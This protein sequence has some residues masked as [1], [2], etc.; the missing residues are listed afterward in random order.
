MHPQLNEHRHPDC[1]EQIQAL[2]RC[3]E[4]AGY[5][6]KL[7][8]YCNGQKQQLDTC[9]R[10][11][12]KEKRSVLLEKARAERARWQERCAEFDGSKGR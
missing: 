5:W 9:F 12:K 10:A 3:H 4:D 6:G 8:G 11:A 1:V 7:L 2:K